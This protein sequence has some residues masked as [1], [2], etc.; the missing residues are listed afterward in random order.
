MFCVGVT[1]R[2]KIVLK[3][4]QSFVHLAILVISMRQKFPGR[5]GPI[6]FYFSRS[7]AKRFDNNQNFSQCSSLRFRKEK[8]N[9]IRIVV[10]VLISGSIK[11]YNPVGPQS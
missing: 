3:A 5:K 10:F 4:M 7:A 2:Q 1:L 6:V 8:F 9:R 11:F